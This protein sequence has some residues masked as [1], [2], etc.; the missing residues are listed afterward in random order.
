[1]VMRERAHLISTEDKAVIAP[2]TLTPAT[3]DFM[4]RRSPADATARTSPLS[5]G[6]RPVLGEN[7][8]PLIPDGDSGMNRWIGA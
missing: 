6:S 8:E 5:D 2:G 7:H 3:D 1:M 4:H